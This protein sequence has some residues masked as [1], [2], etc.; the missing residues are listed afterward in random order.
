MTFLVM[1]LSENICFPS[2]VLQIN[3]IYIL[4]RCFFSCLLNEWISFRV[5]LQ[6]KS[7]VCLFRFV[8]H[9]EFPH[10][11]RSTLVSVLKSL[12]NLISTEKISNISVTISF[13]FDMN[14]SCL[15]SESIIK[16]NCLKY[17]FFIFRVSH[18]H[19]PKLKC[20][21]DKKKQQTINCKK[22]QYLKSKWMERNTRNR[23]VAYDG[24]AHESLTIIFSHSFFIFQTIKYS[25]KIQYWSRN[26]C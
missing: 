18:I 25:I 16:G 10:K 14:A 24:D 5:W 23:Y 7:F 6:S 17:L 3:V 26:F 22:M 13:C 4:R 15:S 9:K 12:C 1:H 20:L 8:F 11:S 19:R 21:S 2:F